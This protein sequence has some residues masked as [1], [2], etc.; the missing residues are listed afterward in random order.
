MSISENLQIIRSFLDPYKTKL[1][2]VSKTYPSETI[3][4]AYNSGQTDFG[5][6]KVQ[7]LM[8][9]YEVLP[10]EIRWHLIGHLQ[11]NKI[12]YIAPFIHLIHS[13]DSFKL[14][15]EIN[16]EAEKSNRTIN[17]L[18]QVHIAQEETKFG[19][20]EEELLHTIQSEELKELKNV[21]IS[22]LMGMASNTEN[23][24][25]IK[26]EFQHIQKLFNK[27]KSSFQTDQI[28]MEELSIGMSSDYKLACKS[29]STM[30][31]VGS[32]IFGSRN[33]L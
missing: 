16:K 29:G 28:K 25:Q 18:L 5:E 12:K 6:N 27:I 17:C 20:S 14:L 26:K 33:Y 31:R 8:S 4:E 22:G 30:V 3:L 2:A 15:K 32:A 13:V 24:E 11:S 7:E 21:R 10:K 1:I 19:F 23:E 9:K